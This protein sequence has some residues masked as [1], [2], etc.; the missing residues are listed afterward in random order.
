M[1][2]ILLTSG[3]AFIFAFTLSA[4]SQVPKECTESWEKMEKLSKKMG[5]PDDQ[6]K[7]HKKEFEDNIKGLSKEE[8]IKACTMQSAF[9]NMA[10]R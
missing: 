3:A 6:I 8:A 5:M 9:L 7:I 10:E 1:N 4:C 2:K